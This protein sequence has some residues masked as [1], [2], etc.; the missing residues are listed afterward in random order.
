MLP[1]G[2]RETRFIYEL[3]HQ[4]EHPV[5]EHLF[6]LRVEQKRRRAARIAA[7]R[8]RVAEPLA[9]LRQRLATGVAWQQQPAG[10][11]CG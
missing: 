3:E 5:S 9:A 6:W 10:N 11:E 1:L 2:P 8:A 4:R 7:L